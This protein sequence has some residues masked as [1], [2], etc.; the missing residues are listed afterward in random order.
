MKTVH[1]LGHK[2]NPNK[3]QKVKSVH[4]VSDHDTIKPES[5]HLSENK[6]LFPLKNKLSLK[7]FKEWIPKLKIIYKDNNE[8][9]TYW[10]D[11]LKSVN[12][13]F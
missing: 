8:S 7:L 5:N 1:T 4:T 10:I 13:H 2:E 12:W 6:V 9:D 11:S 3:L